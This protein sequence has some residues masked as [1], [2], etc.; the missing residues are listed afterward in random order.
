MKAPHLVPGLLALLLVGAALAAGALLAEVAERRAVHA[1]APVQFDQKHLGSALQIEAFE[2]ADLLPVY[3]SSEL[4][5]RSRYQPSVVFSAH[6]TGFVVFTV[7][8][9]GAS[10]LT[11][12][13]SLAAVGRDMQGKK[14][15]ISFTPLPFLKDVGVNPSYY[16]GNFSRLH[17]GELAFSTELSFTVKQSVACRMLHYPSTLKKDPLLRFALEQLDK[18]GPMGRS[19]YYAV[20]PMGRPQ[21]LV[22]QL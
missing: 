17:A 10:S 6:P 11:H 16:A 2:Q 22:L 20:L 19:L 21:N 7:G 5:T 15:V 18:D 4:F 14:V 12:L 9:V 3:G 13:E 8:G 1:L